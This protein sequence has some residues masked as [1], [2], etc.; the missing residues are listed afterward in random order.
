ML[1]SP[2]VSV[3]EGWHEELLFFS[4]DFCL[5]G[6]RQSEI[7]SRSRPTEVEV[8]ILSGALHKVMISA[9]CCSEAWIVRHKG[10]WA[11]AVL[12][13]VLLDRKWGQVDISFSDAPIS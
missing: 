10:G 5:R 11:R 7:I 13:L 12:V 1:H 6:K 4:C 9:A 8:E 3:G 2:S